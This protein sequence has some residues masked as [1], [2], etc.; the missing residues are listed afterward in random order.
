MTG[1]HGGPTTYSTYSA[2]VVNAARAADMA[3]PG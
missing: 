2:E 1:F 3:W